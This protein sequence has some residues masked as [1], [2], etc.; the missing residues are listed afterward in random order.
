MSNYQGKRGQ[1]A[2]ETLFIFGLILIGVLVIVPIYAKQGSDSVL[3]Y[4][5]RDA[6]SQAA[7]YL[8]MGVTS[9][10]PKYVSLNPIVE[11]YTNYSNAGFRFVGV[12]VQLENDT[13]LV[14][15]L[16]F[17]HSLPNNSTLDSSIARAIGI[18]LKEYLKDVK[19][20]SYKNGHIYSRDRMVVFNVTVGETWEVVS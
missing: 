12:R 10:N 4:A 15:K 7:S 9:S 20:L 5:V 2:V 6:S 8:N 16:K 19:G 3:L 13:T 1:T 14:L 17:E 11:R 18:F